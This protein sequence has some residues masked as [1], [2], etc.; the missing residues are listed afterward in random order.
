MELKVKRF[1]ELTADELYRILR[2]RI[3]VFVVEQECPYMEADGLDQNAV[4]VWLE[5]EDGIKAYLRVLDRGAE[6]EHC[7]IGRVIA[8]E[9]RHGLGS[10][11]VKEGVRVAREC[12]G[13][14]AVYLEAQTYAESFYEKQGFRRISDEFMLDGI[15][16]IKM[17]WT[18]SE[19]ETGYWV[20]RK[21]GTDK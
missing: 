18:E 8:A 3:A 4:H 17:L 14:D 1:Q 19:G 11:I 21:E 7:A 6:S 9:R 20:A 13:A 16:H 12:F 10:R 2:L 5:D 15:A